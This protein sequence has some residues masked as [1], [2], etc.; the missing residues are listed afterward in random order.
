MEENDIWNL[1][2]EVN[3]EQELTEKDKKIVSEYSEND[4]LSRDILPIF[5]Y[6]INYEKEN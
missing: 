2:V 6:S 5:D 4:M 3:E 1:E